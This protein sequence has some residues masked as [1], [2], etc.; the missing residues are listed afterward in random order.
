MTPEEWIAEA[1]ETAPPLSDEQRREI[2]RLLSRKP[3]DRAET[4]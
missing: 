3:D 2:V 1:L 4:A